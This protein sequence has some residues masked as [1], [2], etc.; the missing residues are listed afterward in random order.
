[1]EEA[2]NVFIRL[3]IIFLFIILPL[4]VILLINSFEIKPIITK[5][6]TM[7]LCLFFP[8]IL[9]LIGIYVGVNNFDIN[10]F[11]ISSS[12]YYIISIIWFAEGVIFYTALD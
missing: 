8:L 6:L 5:A 12:W 7:F 2:Y 4:L 10:V 1:M 11:D 3:V 9:I